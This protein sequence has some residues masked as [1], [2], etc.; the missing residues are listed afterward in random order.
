VAKAA[1]V[2]QATVS[3]VLNRPELV[4]PDTIRRVR[5]VIDALG[6]VVND[7]ARQLRAGRSFVL[8]VSVH[9]IGNPFWAAVTRG[10]ADHAAQHGFMVA[11]ASTN[12]SV[13]REHRYLRLFEEQRVAGMLVA[14]VDSDLA[15]LRRLA[16]VG[17]AVVLLDAKDPQGDLPYVAV[18]DV[19]GGYVA[20]RH[21]LDLGHRRIACVNGPQDRPWSV[22]RWMGIGLAAQE[23]GLD[24][25]QVLVRE[26]VARLTTHEGRRAAIRVLERHPD[27]TAIFCDNDMLA[28]GAMHALAEHGIDVPDRMSVIGYDDDEF[29]EMLS[30]SLTTVRQ[31]PYRLGTAAAEIALS[32]V[33]TWGSHPVWSSSFVPAL[34]LRRSTGP[35]AAGADLQQ[36]VGPADARGTA[37][38]RGWRQTV[39]G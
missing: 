4:A 8:G 25:T 24:P 22:D 34:V 29:T 21:L 38:G 27:V 2:S 7:G 26:P 23:R 15:R 13:A 5:E 35:C 39:G 18:D 31:E 17:T 36:D 6:F 32:L 16:S 28:L 1:G 9:D 11:L 12:E 20:G 19:R 30:P 10:V 14:P 3:N 37:P 33:R